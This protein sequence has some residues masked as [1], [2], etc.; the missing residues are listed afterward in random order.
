[1]ESA[2]NPYLKNARLAAILFF[3]LCLPSA[4]WGLSYVSSKIFVA[5]DPATTVSN[6]LSNEFLFRTGIVSHF[7]GTI[8]F[9]Y[10]VLLFYRAF[11][12]VSR[13]ITM[14]MLIIVVAQIP[15]VFVLEL[16][17]ITAL[18]IVKDGVLT[19]VANMEKQEFVY[20]LLRMHGWGIGMSQAF[21]GLFF[22]PFGMLIYRSRYAPRF[23][24]ILVMITGTGYIAD[25]L[26]FIML[27]RSDFLQVQPF[28]KLTL[29]GGVLA[30]L[31]FLIVGA[32]LPKS[33]RKSQKEIFET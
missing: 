27:Q 1:M 23:L 21:W 2:P 16:L 18:Y 33:T 13:H 14:A 17:K 28:I 30:L 19:T 24:G 4:L 7:I 3:S 12:P 31:W 10:M 6:I 29:V 22:L 25:T 9:I 20:L 15:I 5:R 8:A 26:G 32:R 11:R